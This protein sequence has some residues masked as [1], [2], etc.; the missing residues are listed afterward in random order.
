MTTLSV[1]TRS[2]ADGAYGCDRGVLRLYLHE[3]APV[4]GDRQALLGQ[5]TV[6]MLPEPARLPTET[7]DAASMR[8]AH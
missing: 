3:I 4:D 1:D 2:P 8:G 7:A 5:I 6:R